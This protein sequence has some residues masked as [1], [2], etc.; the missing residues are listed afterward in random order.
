MNSSL[1]LQV[2]LSALNW[3]EEGNPTQR[4][5]RV[6]GIFTCWS[7][8]IFSYVIR[9]ELAIRRDHTNYRLRSFIS[10]C[11]NTSTV[12][13]IFGICFGFQTRKLPIS[14]T[15]VH[16]PSEVHL[17]TGCLPTVNMHSF[18]HL[19]TDD[20]Q[21]AVPAQ[22]V[23][24]N[25]SVQSRA[26]L[27]LDYV[28]SIAQ[29]LSPNSQ[30]RILQHTLFKKIPFLLPAVLCA[31]QLFSRGKP[32]LRKVPSVL[33][34]DWKRIAACS[35][36][37]SPAHLLFLGQGTV[38]ITCTEST[39]HWCKALVQVAQV[40][41]RRLVLNISSLTPSALWITT[42]QWTHLSMDAYSQWQL[43]LNSY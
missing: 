39:L 28:Q 15:A 3:H 32:R 43:N 23:T 5:C 31:Y 29:T 8:Y 26:L 41:F 30:F 37:V 12:W 6:K 4:I 38:H 16:I 14:I 19:S 25:C 22:V 40:K 2:R 11:F 13:T 42:F 7:I 35:P 1:Q 33:S 18:V 10:S 17:A 20:F 24:Q 9:Q 21:T 36:L 27:L 34:T